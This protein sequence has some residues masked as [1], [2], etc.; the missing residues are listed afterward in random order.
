MLV[1]ACASFAG[2]AQNSKKTVEVSVIESMGPAAKDSTHLSLQGLV[3]D[4][5]KIKNDDIVDIEKPEYKFV[6]R[7]DLIWSK[8]TYSIVDL[9]EKANLPLYYPTQS[10][11]DL[12]EDEFDYQNL[13]QKRRSL[14]RALFEGIKLG[15]I[16][17]FETTSDFEFDVLTSYSS[18]RDMGLVKVVNKQKA[19]FEEQFGQ[20]D[21]PDSLTIRWDVDQVYQFLVK[22]FWYID[23][24]SSRLESMILGLC[25]IATITTEM[26]AED[27]STIETTGKTQLCWIYY[28][29]A[30]AYLAKVPYYDN[31]NNNGVD[32]YTLDDVLLSR[33]FSSYFIGEENA[34]NN[35]DIIDY[36]TGREAQLESD[37]IKNE[38]F[39]FEQDLWEY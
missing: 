17:A 22:E 28:P 39:N 3:K 6:R 1:I 11:T 4:D 8:T 24:R 36:A 15:Q 30:R 31:R 10:L 26:E 7:A 27:G 14:I 13:F 2:F 16:D 29:Q 5:E 9:R 32:T 18:I 20:A 25:P 38:I 37:R 19:I 12:D 35:R 33:H 23:K 34:Y 21:M